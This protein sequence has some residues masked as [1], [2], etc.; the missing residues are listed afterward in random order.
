MNQPRKK[1]SSSEDDNEDNDN[2]R[3]EDED[4]EDENKS[5][6][7]LD[8]EQLQKRHQELRALVDQHK[9]MDLHRKIERA[10]HSLRCPPGDSPVDMLSGGE[11]RRYIFIDII[12]T[13]E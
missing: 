9:L 6:E 2:D 10:I 11:R 7:P 4:E 12:D 1:K 5:T 3:D 13:I 8:I